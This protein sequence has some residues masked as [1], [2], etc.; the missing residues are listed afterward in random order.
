MGVRVS[1][2]GGH[3]LQL[4]SFGMR[5]RR[6]TTRLLLAMLFL[7]C[8]ITELLLC[9]HWLLLPGVRWDVGDQWRRLEFGCFLEGVELGVA[10]FRLF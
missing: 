7:L 4:Q 8:G 5:S 6:Y 3:E 9:S 1:G 2:G 10:W